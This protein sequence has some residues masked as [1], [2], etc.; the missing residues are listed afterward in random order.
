MQVWKSP[1]CCWHIRIS[2][3]LDQFNILSKDITGE[4]QIYN[5]LSAPN[6]GGPVSACVCANT[7]QYYIGGVLKNC[8]NTGLNQCVQIIGYANY[9]TTGAYWIVRYE[10]N[11]C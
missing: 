3:Y 6:T 2:K 11:A 7:W 9:N 5:Q 10:V 4:L 8:N 1:A